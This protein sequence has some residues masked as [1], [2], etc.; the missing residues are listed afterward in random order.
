MDSLSRV[1]ALASVLWAG[2]TLGIVHDAA[3][4]F[5]TPDVPRLMLLRVGMHLFRS[6]R[7]VET[8]LAA[9]LAALEMR[10]AH[11]GVNR[12]LVS[13]VLLSLVRSY[14]FPIPQLLRDGDCVIAGGGTCQDPSLERIASVAH[15]TV[16]ITEMLK[17]GLLIWGAAACFQ[18]QKR[19]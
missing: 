4:K 16:V 1:S 10:R 19:A 6:F 8:L 3:V 14:A 18:R 15:A 13:A 12:P 2:M 11:E 17:I 9:F 5:S 7:I